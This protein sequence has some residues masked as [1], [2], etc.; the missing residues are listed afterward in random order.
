MKHRGY[1]ILTAP[2]DENCRKIIA[3]RNDSAGQ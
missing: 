3:E 1:I 2:D